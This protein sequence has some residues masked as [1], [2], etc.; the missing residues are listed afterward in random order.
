MILLLGFGQEHRNKL[1]AALADLRARFFEAHRV[2]ELGQ[3]FL[4]RACMQIDGVDQRAVNVEDCGQWHG[5]V[6]CSA[7]KTTRRPLVGC[8][9]RKT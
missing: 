6:P 8:Y 9:T 2:A 1:V 7:W 5:V 4:P 3:G